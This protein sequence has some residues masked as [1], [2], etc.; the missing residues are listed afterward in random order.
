M[1]T[2]ISRKDLDAPT[3]NPFL[4]YFY[5]HAAAA[6]AVAAAAA[7]DDDA[8]D[9]HYRCHVHKKVTAVA[10]DNYHLSCT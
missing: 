8:D 4:F 2:P 5:N 6:A 7:A 1:R 3:P 9:A 10:Y